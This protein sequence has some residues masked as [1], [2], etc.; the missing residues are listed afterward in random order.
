[1][2]NCRSEPAFEQEIRAFMEELGIEHFPTKKQMLEAGKENLY[3]NIVERGGVCKYA[4]HM[5]LQL[6]GNRE[7]ALCWGC[8]HAVPNPGK[9]RGCEWSKEFLPVPGWVASVRASFP[10]S[11]LV[12]SC[13]KF[14]RG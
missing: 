10:D 9:G 11:Y 6:R 7:D 13:P 12:K 2:E 4:K 1:M 14:E 8:A 3:L 5:K